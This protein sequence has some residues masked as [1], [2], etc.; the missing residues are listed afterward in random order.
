MH[1]L[2]AG[3]HGNLNVNSKGGSTFLQLSELNG[4]NE[5]NIENQEKESVI[6]ITEEIEKNTQIQ[7]DAGVVCLEK[8]LEHVSSSLS[9]DRSKFQLSNQSENQLVISS[10]GKN[11][12]RLGKMSWSDMMFEA[13]NTTN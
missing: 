9:Q 13:F 6:N 12:V 1:F 10:K 5:I 8:E 3:V 4:R 11:G 7:V 2:L